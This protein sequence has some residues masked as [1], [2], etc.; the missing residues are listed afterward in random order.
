MD[1]SS[2]GPRVSKI[3]RARKWYRCGRKW[4]RDNIPFGIRTI[5]GL[6]LVALG[7]VGFLPVVGFWML[8]LGVAIIALDLHILWRKARQMKNR[9][10]GSEPPD[11][12]E[13]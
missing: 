2:D 12:K 8:P 6:F 7:L 13:N 5:L 10:N 1:S 4:I 11:D 9:I 3:D